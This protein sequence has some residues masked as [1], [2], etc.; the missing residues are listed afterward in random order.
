MTR[1]SDIE[2]LS[3]GH[4]SDSE[5]KTGCTVILAPKGAAASGYFPGFAPALHE[6][7][8]LDPNNPCPVIHGLAL[9]GGSAFGLAAAAGVVRFLSEN[10]IGLET[11]A[12]KVP[13]VPAASIYDYPYNLSEGKLPDAAA[14]YAAAKEAS[15]ASG[16][17][18]SQRPEEIGPLG[19]GVSARCGKMGEPNLSSPSGLGFDGFEDGGLKLSALAVANPLGSV[20]D[21]ASGHVLSGLKT[22][23]GGLASHQEILEALKKRGASERGF[24]GRNTVLAAV[25]TN[26]R[27]DKTEIYRL[28]VM[29]S[30]G[31]GRAV[32]PSNTLYD[33]DAIFALATGEDPEADLNWLGAMAAQAVSGAI[34]AAAS[35]AL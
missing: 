24:F 30:A 5:S 18:A 12:I 25:A 9:C 26:A 15:K 6:T 16:L 10:G 19:A 7:G 3:L 21:P 27:I 20:I 33:G 4:W 13:I 34:R 17:P 8:V 31:I 35:F 1:V 32:F 22:P 2:G 29:A 11:G 14:G 28:A 23:C